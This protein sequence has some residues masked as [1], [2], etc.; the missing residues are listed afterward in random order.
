MTSKRYATR[1]FKDAGTGRNFKA[2]QELTD[3]TDGE[4]V[5]YEHAGLAGD[6]PKAT[7]VRDKAPAKRPAKA[8]AKKVAKPA[9]KIADHD[10]ANTENAPVEGA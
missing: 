9:A 8:A 10:P 6:P 4:L 2:N 1:D 3:L 5:N 7:P